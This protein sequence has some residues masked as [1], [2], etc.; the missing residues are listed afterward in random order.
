MPGM[1]RLTRLCIARFAGERGQGLVLAAA[2]MVIILGFAALAIDVGRFL[3]ERRELQNAA[4]AAAMAGVRDLPS[5]PG[6]A[7]SDAQEWAA[8]NDIAP[9]ELESVDV[10][11][12]YV[13]NDT[14]TV[15]VKRD[16]PFLFGRVLGLSGDTMH[17]T[18]K[19]RAGSAAGMAGLR[20]FG[21]LESAIKYDEPTILKYDSK[22]VTNGNFG[23]LA[24]DGSGS[25]VYRDTIKYGSH[26]E[27]CAQDQPG[28][29]HYIVPTEPGNMVGPTE[30]GVQYLLSNTAGACDEFS[31]VLVPDT[32]TPDPNDYVLTDRCNPYKP[33]PPGDSQR[34]I[35]TP[36]I[37]HLCNG[38][39]DVTIQYFAMFFL[40]D[41][42]SCTGNDCQVKGR[43]ARANVDLGAL[44]GAYNPNDGVAFWRL[45]E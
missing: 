39:C 37:D 40:E 30:K 4:D 44:L 1:M 3:H 25:S 41:L 38:R 31:E 22:D 19:A 10:S 28:C 32:S 11:S 33:S 21:V 23:A 18:A 17:A 20:P 36:V 24:L 6:A 8:K 45:V 9:G 27:V 29:S 14:L 42:P 15:T 7:T 5:S 43:F 16:V 26:T 12:T 13:A 35:I 2:A 34:V